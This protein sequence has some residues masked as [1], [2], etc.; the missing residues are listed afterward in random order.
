[1]MNQKKICVVGLG[2][3]G[4]Y[5]GTLLASHHQNVYFYARGRRLASIREKGITM[6]SAAQGKVSAFP[7]LASDQAETLGVMDYIFLCV[8]DFSLGQVLAEISPMI[9]DHTMIIPL[10]NGVGVAEKIR[11]SLSQGTVADGL[12]YIIAETDQD[13]AVHLTSPYCKIFIGY[14]GPD[15]YPGDKLE[16]VQ[17][18][19]Q[20][21]G[22]TCSIE[23]DIEAAIW[24]KYILNCAYNV[25]TAYY[26]GTT[27]DL[28]ANAAAV[29]QLKTLLEEASAVARK[30]KV[31]ITDDLEA[32]HLDHI[33]HV[34]AGNST[35]SLKRDM[36]AGKPNELAVFSGKLLELAAA[37]GLKLPLTEYFYE[38]LK[39]RSP[40]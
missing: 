28:R 7:K 37:A 6:Y 4:G 29:S 25:L 24:K 26:D 2:G 35:S 30:L 19:L 12:V 16:E 27:N 21:A 39:K 5:L 31:R 1:M 36:A 38:E 32:V 22:I 14:A 10:L 40:Q 20:E 11:Q 15:E 17:D 18:L 23:G 13:Y 33:L 3:V 8:K 9:R 34:Q